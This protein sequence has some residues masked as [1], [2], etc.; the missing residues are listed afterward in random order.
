MQDAARARKRPVSKL[1]RAEVSHPRAAMA[2]GGESAGPAGGE[3][4]DTDDGHLGSID[5]SLPFLLLAVSIAVLAKLGRRALPEAF[6]PPFSVLLFLSG[7]VI[8]AI[9]T[10]VDFGPLGTSIAD[11][12]FV[13]PHGILFALL[14]PLLFESA[15][16]MDFHIFW[17]VAGQAVL[18]AVPGVMMCVAMTATFLRY[19]FAAYNWDW[20]TS[21]LLGSILSATDP[22]A[23]VAVL[24]TLGAPK[25][26]RALIEGE[27]LLNDGSAF[28]L[29]LIFKDIVAAEAQGI[30]AP[31]AGEMIGTFAQL[32]LGGPIVGYIIAVL[33]VIF[34]RQVYNDKFVEVSG[35]LVVV[36]GTFFFAET[37]IH[38]S[39]VLAVV[40][41][42]LY[43]SA[44]GKY[45][46]SREVEE[47]NH[48]IW[49]E[50]AWLAD[51]L[52]FVLA[53]VVIFR[54]VVQDTNVAGDPLNW[55]YLGLLYVMLHVVRG[56]AVW[57]LFPVLRRLGYGVNWKEG[58]VMVWGGLRGAVGLALGLLVE[59]DPH[60]P[61]E[62]KVLINFHISGIVFLTLLVNGTTAAK[63]Y[64]KL[65]IYP[66][67]PFREVL[68]RR[69]LSM[70]ETETERHLEA[71]KELWQHQKISARWTLVEALVPK[72]GDCGVYDGRVELPQDSVDSIFLHHINRMRLGA[73]FN[74]AVMAT[75]T[76]NRAKAKGKAVAQR[77]R[78]M[79][80]AKRSAGIRVPQPTDDRSSEDDA[81]AAGSAAQ[82]KSTAPESSRNSESSAP[83]M[84][85]VE[86]GKSINDGASSDLGSGFG[87]D[88]VRIGD[89]DVDA[90]DSDGAEEGKSEPNP[91]QSVSQ[92]YGVDRLGRKQ[93][94]LAVG[95][96]VIS[97]S[98]SGLRQTM[99]RAQMILSVAADS[100]GQTPKA[101]GQRS[102][103]AVVPIAEGDEEAV[104]SSSK[105]GSR[106]ASSAD[107][108]AKGTRERRGSNSSVNSSLASVTSAARRRRRSGGMARKRA[109]ESYQSLFQ[110]FKAGFTHHY[111]MRFMGDAALLMLIEG[112]DHGLE[113][114]KVHHAGVPAG[115]QRVR[116]ALSFHADPFRAAFSVIKHRVQISRMVQ[117]FV[118][119]APKIAYI[120]GLV[121]KLVYNEVASAVEALQGLLH[122]LV[123]MLEDE[124]VIEMLAPH[125]VSEMKWM[126]KQAAKQLRILEANHGGICVVVHTLLPVKV[127]LHNLRE[128]I[129]E[130]HASHG[131][132]DSAVADDLLDLVDQR[133]SGLYSYAPAAR[134]LHYLRHISVDHA[135]VDGHESAPHAVAHL[136]PIGAHGRHSPKRRPQ[137]VVTRESGH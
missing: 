95:R 39:G 113:W 81:A 109:E 74:A 51:S 11:W 71:V 88:A 115:S 18:L 82:K 117:F 54:E 13:H 70:L 37:V 25:K 43:M 55:A 99:S 135:N 2:S 7:L 67:N 80:A 72:F 64:T 36:F 6:R 102:S 90:S 127:V 77:A 20:G 107:P 4:G 49:S 84:D 106:A 12:S 96:P 19:G 111:E 60:I 41:F 87:V 42:G 97:V 69:A 79:A 44:R 105:D 30:E 86:L 91:V 131:Y 46:L 129:V 116:K 33:F 83:S 23:V 93:S 108:A 128:T 24:Q 58:V 75:M 17:R 57:M 8:A 136:A 134:Q 121:D 66:V 122:A 65:D 101:T 124:G 29:F 92:T 133:L 10:A 85:V 61:A 94:A 63:I 32:A 16:G 56:L 28:V 78:A 98:T 40:V 125:I 35:L 114:V 14:P 38:V 15:F 27:S 22:V 73:I 123:E 47:Q 112:C 104:D 130:M 50:V 3:Q 59:L 62:K 118:R 21:L 52:V 89:D 45:A 9:A 1:F 76:L 126:K 103:R 110:A 5:I 68:V 120:E 132:F 119:R 48:T 137:A 31:G 26:L 34:V 100:T 53:G